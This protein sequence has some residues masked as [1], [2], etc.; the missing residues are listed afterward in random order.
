M[1]YKSGL[2]L[3]E[4]VVTTAI[5][6][7]VMTSVYTAFNAG[8]FGFRNIEESI[9]TYQAARGVL[10]RLNLDLANAFS[11]SQEDSKFQGSQQHLSFLTLIDTFTGQELVPVYSFVSYDQQADKLMRLCRKGQLALNENSQVEPDE[12]ASSVEIKFEYGFLTAKDSQMQFKDSWA[13]TG[14]ILEEK[15]NFPLAIRVS[16]TVKGK[17]T[18][19]FKRTIYIPEKT[20]G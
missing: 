11:F 10:E 15:N 5:I 4:V 8:I 3:I 18:Q 14:N 12:M 1:K 7:V 17:T 6:A 13:T 20:N 19:E 2:T 9:N 16:L